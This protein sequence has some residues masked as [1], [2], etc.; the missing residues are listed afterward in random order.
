[1]ACCVDEVILEAAIKGPDREHAGH[2]SEVL[3]KAAPIEV[4]NQ[5]VSMLSRKL[6]VLAQMGRQSKGPITRSS[7]LMKD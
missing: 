1:M 2:E 3:F 7:L 6:L 4:G 5:L